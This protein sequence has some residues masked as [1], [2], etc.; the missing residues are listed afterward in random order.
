MANNHIFDFGNRGLINTQKILN[1]NSIKFF[2]AGLNKA[3]SITPAVLEVDKYTIAFLG[4][5][6]SNPAQEKKIWCS[7]FI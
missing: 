7:I 3:A 5:S 1:Q 4:F 6:F 2:G